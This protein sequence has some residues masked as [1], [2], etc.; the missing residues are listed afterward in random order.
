MR[1]RILFAALVLCFTFYLAA[2]PSIG[3]SQPPAQD[4]Q[5]GGFGKKG[6]KKGGG[7]PT[8]GGGGFGKKGGFG[9]QQDPNTVFDYVYKGQ[10][11][12]FIVVDVKGYLPNDLKLWI[13]QNKVSDGKISRDQFAKYW[14]A[15][16]DLKKQA[17]DTFGKDGFGKRGADP[18]AGFGKKGG[19]PTTDKAAYDFT[20]KKGGKKASR[21]TTTRSGPSSGSRNTTRTATASSTPTS[22]IG[23]APS[24]A[25]GSSSTP[26]R[27]AP[28]N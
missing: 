5:G 26:T 4:P 6:G 22:L 20:G 23:P 13:E 3:E 24:A 18:S 7:D 11:K 27:A 10:G 14:A 8:A 17:K 25:S 16:D 21:R 12:D 15:R 28:S 2:D 9:G 19:D 1:F